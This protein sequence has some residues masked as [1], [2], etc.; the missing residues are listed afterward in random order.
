MRNVILYTG[1]GAVLLLAMV[2]VV[3]FARR[4][5]VIITVRGDS[6]QPTLQPGDRVLVL[7]GRGHA[8]GRGR[9][10]VIEQ[11][12]PDTGWQG[13]APW[14]GRIEGR[15]WSIKRVAAIAQDP[16]PVEVVS[17]ESRVPGG[18]LVVLGDNYRSAD[19]R[20]FGF[21]PIERILGAV[22]LRLPRR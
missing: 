19:S 8:L 18:H 20:V 7:R 10:V 5:F 14:D 21:L 15:P 22:V 6:M 12:D 4:R 16:V 13:L 3:L 2:A 17:S 1:A 9:I 11:P